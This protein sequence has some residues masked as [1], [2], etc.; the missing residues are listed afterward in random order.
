MCNN[1]VVVVTKGWNTASCKMLLS[2]LINF[3]E[4]GLVLAN[5]DCTIV[6]QFVEPSILRAHPAFYHLF[7]PLFGS[8]T[9]GVVV[10]VVVVI[11][12][13]I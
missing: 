4:S 7:L 3:P 1:T 8:G 11:V 9:G 13:V 2:N 5:F 12:V 10:V 6:H